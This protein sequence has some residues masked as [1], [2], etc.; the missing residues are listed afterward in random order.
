MEEAGRGWGGLGV[1]GRNWER[2]GYWRYRGVLEFLGG[3]GGTG[4]YWDRLEF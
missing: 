1:I 4:G 3:I 2:L